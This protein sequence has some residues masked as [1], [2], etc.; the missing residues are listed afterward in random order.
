[1]RCRGNRCS[2]ITTKQC[3]VCGVHY[4]SA[5]CQRNDWKEHKLIC[6]KYLYQRL[7]IWVE[8]E[9]EDNKSLKEKGISP[10]DQVIILGNNAQNMPFTKGLFLERYCGICERQLQY[11]GSLINHMLTIKSINVEYA[12]C[13]T[14]ESK[15]RMLMPNFLPYDSELL[16]VNIFLCLR[17]HKIIKDIIKIIIAQTFWLNRIMANSEN[18]SLRIPS[19]TNMFQMDFDG[20][21]NGMEPWILSPSNEN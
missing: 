7:N 14:C 1:M 9:K 12:R 11:K 17:Y 18:K 8:K 2:S 16:F 13:E 5:K 15:N 21:E 6:R 3:S 10:Q 19:M 4:C 20:D